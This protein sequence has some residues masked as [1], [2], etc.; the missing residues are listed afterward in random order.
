MA[1]QELQMEFWHENHCMGSEKHTNCFRT[2]FEAQTTNAGENSTIVTIL[3]EPDV[4]QSYLGPISF[5]M[6]FKD[7]NCPLKICCCRHGLLH[8]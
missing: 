2:C 4:H 5:E 6:V 8:P 7:A 1:L 3:R